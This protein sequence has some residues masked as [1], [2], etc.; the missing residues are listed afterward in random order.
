MKKYSKEF[1]PITKELVHTEY[2]NI[3]DFIT[4]KKGFNKGK[5]NIIPLSF[6]ETRINLPKYGKELEN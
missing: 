2:K 5:L 3:R 6:E 4:Q 1:D